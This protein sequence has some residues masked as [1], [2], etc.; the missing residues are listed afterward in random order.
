MIQIPL[1]NI[2]NQ[3][4]SIQ[5]DENQFDLNFHATQ[6]NIDGSSGVTGVDIVM[7]NVVIVSGMRAVF[8]T[9]LI[10]YIYLENGN[11]A[12]VTQND[13][14]PDWRQF[15]ITQFLIYASQSELE[16]IYANAQ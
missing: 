10:P 8:G 1:Q 11:F 9:F 14:Y 16:T 7:N 4:L 15:G 5:L 2:A 3:S 13:D 12:F 6:D